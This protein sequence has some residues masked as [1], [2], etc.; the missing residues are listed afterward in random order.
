LKEFQCYTG[1]ECKECGIVEM[2]HDSF[3]SVETEVTIKISIPVGKYC[4]GW[5]SDENNEH[6]WYRCPA[7]ISCDCFHVHCNI[8][9]KRVNEG[10][11]YNGREFHSIKHKDCP[12]HEDKRNYR[13]SRYIKE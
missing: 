12:I 2:A 1:R 5:I 9:N 4:E 6:H 7:L 3:R 11:K 8:L 10:S 13:M